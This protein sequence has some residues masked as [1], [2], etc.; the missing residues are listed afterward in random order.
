MYRTATAWRSSVLSAGGGL[1]CG[2]VPDVSTPAE[3]RAA[4]TRTAE[5]LTRLRL[6][7]R[8]EAGADGD[9]WTGTVTETAPA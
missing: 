5:A 8:W 7:V 1:L 9:S 2:A 3:A 4:C 6:T